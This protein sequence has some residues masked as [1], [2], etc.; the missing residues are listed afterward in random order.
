MVSN[1]KRVWDGLCGPH[2]PVA[3]NIEIESVIGECLR[4]S[5]QSVLAEPIPQRF[6]DLIQLLEQE[7][8][9]RAKRGCD[10]R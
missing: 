1:R 3:K 4:Q 2:A 6:I 8:E 9:N 5:F 10:E 7:D